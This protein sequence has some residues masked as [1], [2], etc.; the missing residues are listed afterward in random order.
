MAEFRIQIAG[1]V[2][3][4]CSMFDSTRDYCRNYLTE[5]APDVTVAVTPEA[6][7]AQ[8]AVLDLEADRE[9]LRR[10]VFTAPFLERTAI[11]QRAAEL[12][13]AYDVLLMHGSAVA[14]DGKGYI[15]TAPCGT[16]KST[17][18]R[19]WRQ[20]F[21]GRAIMINDDKPFLQVAN[22]GIFVCGA[23]WSGKHGLDTNICVPL[24]GICILARGEENRIQPARTEEVSDFLSHQCQAPADPARLPQFRQLVQ[25]LVQTVPLWRM[26]CTLSPEAAQIAYNTMSQV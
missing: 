23:P 24:Q 7:T 3:A 25:T 9:G 8:Q 16:G 2:I 21:C 11:Q 22:D 5:D 17:H 1:R 14:V 6:L 19:L 13:L 26:E 4:V 10:R 12:L 18:T 20:V 15:F